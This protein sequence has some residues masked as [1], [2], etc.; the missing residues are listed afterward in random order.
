MGRF[1]IRDMIHVAS[2]TSAAD[3]PSCTMATYAG[4]GSPRFTWK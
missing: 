2:N 4:C 3:M 1:S